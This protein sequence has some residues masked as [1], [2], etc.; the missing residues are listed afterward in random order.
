[1]G[2]YQLYICNYELE[3]GS[4]IQKVKNL[5]ADWTLDPSQ[6][7]NTS[8]IWLQWQSFPTGVISTSK[9]SLMKLCVKC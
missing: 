7:S 8:D 6:I 1:V 2:S 4:F 3:V 5:L 9:P